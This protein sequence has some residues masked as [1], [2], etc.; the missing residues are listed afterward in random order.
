MLVRPQA[1]Q[2]AS[3]SEVTTRP[4]LIASPE[5]RSKGW[6]TSSSSSSLVPTPSHSFRNM[7]TIQQ[8]QIDKPHCQRKTTESDPNASLVQSRSFSVALFH[9][10]INIF[11]WEIRILH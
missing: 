8:Y 2:G 4:S 9:Y 11:Q 5:C 7:N 10:K 3:L 1:C 6:L